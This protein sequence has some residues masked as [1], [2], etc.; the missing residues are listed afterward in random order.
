[1]RCLKLVNKFTL[2][3]LFVFSLSACVTT[4]ENSGFT[5]NSSP[6]SALLSHIEAAYE[7]LRRGDFENA[8]RHLRNAAEINDRDATVHNAMAYSY[9]LSGDLDLADE[10]Y[11]KAI[12]LDGSL[13][14]ARNNYGVFLFKQERYK[15]AR[16][17]FLKVV[18]DTLYL[19]RG[20]AFNSLGVCELRLENY[21]GAKVAFER[22]LELD[23][24]NRAPLLELAA[25]GVKQNDFEYARKKYDTYK[26]VAS[27]SARSLLLGA[28]I[29]EH[30]NMKNDLAS[31]ELALKNRFPDSFEYQEFKKRFK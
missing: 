15:V 20:G 29:A 4:T 10:T 16:E 27:Q 26:L 17:Q 9:E 28:E 23:R 1:M 5:N 12:S 24:L 14:S 11:R 8:R 19:R 3:V 21:D 25:V 7:Y 30:Y 6:E 13:T 22:A 18:K 31:I 2:M